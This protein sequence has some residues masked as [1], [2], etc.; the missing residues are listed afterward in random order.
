MLTMERLVNDVLMQIRYKQLAVRMYI[1][2]H[3]SNGIEKT[4]NGSSGILW[5]RSKN[6]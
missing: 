3:G 2:W 5:D 6:S 1:N 4:L